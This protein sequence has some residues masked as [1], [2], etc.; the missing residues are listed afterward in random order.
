VIAD[1]VGVLLL[2]RTITSLQKWDEN[3]SLFNDF[4]EAL[5]TPPRND[6]KER[7]SPVAV[8]K[9]LHLLAPHFFPLWDN[10]RI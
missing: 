9:A 5:K 8:A 2:V 6:K 4:L 3:K 10:K 1:G 7:K